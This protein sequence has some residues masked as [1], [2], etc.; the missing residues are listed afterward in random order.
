MARKSI[1]DRLCNG[2]MP[3]R[4]RVEELL[5]SHD[6]SGSFLNQPLTANGML[7]TSLHPQESPAW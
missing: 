1:L 2:D 5:A 3:L 6:Q 4:Q 7:H